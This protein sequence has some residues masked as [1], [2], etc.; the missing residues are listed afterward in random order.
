MKGFLNRLGVIPSLLFG[1]SLLGLGLLAL[2]HIVDNWWPFDVER[3]DLVR[4]TAQGTI[5]APSLMAAANSEIILAFL[6]AVLVAITG[7]V[8]PFVFFLNKRFSGSSQ[9]PGF[10]LTLRQAM[11]EV[12][13]LVRSGEDLVLLGVSLGI[14]AAYGPPFADPKHFETLVSGVERALSR[15]EARAVHVRRIALSSWSR[16][17]EAIAEILTQPIAEKVRALILLDSLHASREPAPGRLALE[18]FA[19]FAERAARGE[20]FFLVSHSSIDPPDY[21]STTETARY[22]VAA[23]GGV[24]TPALRKDPLGLELFEIYEKGRF[25][26]RGYTG[27]GKLDHC[28]HFGVY[29][30]AVQGLSR[31][32]RGAPTRK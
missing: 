20:T 9:T 7:L 1:L 11:S 12:A 29:A 16:G 15:R 32:F 25:Y 3:L 13:R 17:Y 26:E 8:L 27:N 2:N 14:G 22:L 24:P 21:A 4:A 5:D 28:A 10:L 6:A 18:P 23:L 30:E 19:R 31:F